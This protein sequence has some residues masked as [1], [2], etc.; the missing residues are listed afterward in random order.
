MER[1]ASELVDIRRLNNTNP[2]TTKTKERGKPRRWVA[3]GALGAVAMSLLVATTASASSSPEQAPKIESEPATEAEQSARV[4]LPVEFL[5]AEAE[6]QAVELFAYLEASKQEEAR[7]VGEY[8]TML[9][10]EEARAAQQAKTRQFT[11]SSPSPAAT[12]G[13]VWDQLAQCESGGNWSINTENGYYG[14]V[15][16]SYSTWLAMG[17]GQYAERAD[18]ASREQ[19][20]VI[21]E[22]TLASGGWGQWPQCSAE[23]GLS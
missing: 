8:I 17:G 18:L 7:K 9:Q 6:H 16:F 11:A 19:Q 23:L 1:P 15:Q 20:I 5:A 22:R 10:E 13:S 21:A 4:G 14:G 2:D 12:G 3:K